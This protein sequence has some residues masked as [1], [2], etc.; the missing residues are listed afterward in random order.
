MNKQGRS[1]IETIGGIIVFVFI[2]IVLFGSGAIAA[3]LQ[4]FPTSTF[5]GYGIL[6]GAGFVILIIATLFE[7]IM[8]K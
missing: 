2:L 8:D 5:G 4:A 3:I 7:R 6:L 1:D